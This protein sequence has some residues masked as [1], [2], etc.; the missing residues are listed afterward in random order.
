VAAHGFAESRE[1]R[2]DVRVFAFHADAGDEQRR[3][4]FFFHD[5]VSGFEDL[6]RGFLSR[7]DFVE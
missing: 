2:A 6:P 4:S 7:D 1:A 3:E 5:E